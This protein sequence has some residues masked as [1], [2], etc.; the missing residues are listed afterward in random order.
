[1]L[2][3]PIKRK[4]SV[5][6]MLEQLSNGTSVARPTKRVCIENGKRKK[7]D[8]DSCPQPAK[9]GKVERFIT[10]TC[11]GAPEIKVPKLPSVLRQRIF[12]NKA[13]DHG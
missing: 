5:E 12:P 11:T 3:G 2:N 13:D 6:P 10:L 9:K 1:M 4:Q 8:A 7:H